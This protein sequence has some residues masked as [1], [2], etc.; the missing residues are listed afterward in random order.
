MKIRRMVLRARWLPRLQNQEA[1]DLTNDEF[2]HFDPKK[3]IKVELAD[4]E[5]KVMNSLFE[6]GDAYMAELDSVRT[7]EKEKLARRKARGE[8]TRDRRDKRLK[9]IRETQPW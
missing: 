6:V 3:R 7:A 1:D 8:D 2:R 4:L 9:G 5:F